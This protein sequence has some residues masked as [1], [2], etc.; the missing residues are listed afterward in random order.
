MT[1]RDRDRNIAVAAVVLVVV[2]IIFLRFFPLVKTPAKQ[3]TLP[4]HLDQCV[5][6]GGKLSMHIHSQLSIVIDGQAQPIPAN[7]GLESFCMRPIHT[8]DDSGTLHLEFPQ[9]RDVRLGDFFAIW[10]KRFDQNCVLDRCAEANPSAGSPRSN[11]GQAGQ[12]KTLKLRVNGK[13][14]TEFER[15]VMHDKDKIEIIFK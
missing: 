10:G 13:D 1:K 11:S 3:T 5:E 9:T 2:L 8:H 7:I 6:H 4:P 15:Y 12:G 14:N